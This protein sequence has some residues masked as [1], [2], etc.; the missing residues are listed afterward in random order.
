M[1]MARLRRLAQRQAQIQQPP[2]ARGGSLTSSGPL[3]A[4]L[5]ASSARASASSRLGRAP[6]LLSAVLQQQPQLYDRQRLSAVERFIDVLDELPSRYRDAQVRY[7]PGGRAWLLL[8][9]WG[10]RT[11]AGGCG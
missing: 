1:R 11:A 2:P 3:Q 5:R 4:G 10:C 6:V 9:A 7:A 8:G